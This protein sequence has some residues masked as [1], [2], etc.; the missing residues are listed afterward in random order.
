MKKWLCVG[1]FGLSIL[2]TSLL[3][4]ARAAEYITNGGFEETDWSLNGG[5]PTSHHYVYKNGT[6]SGEVDGWTYTPNTTTTDYGFGTDVATTTSLV[7]FVAEGD[8]A[9]FMQREGQVAQSINLTSGNYYTLTFKYNARNYQTTLNTKVGSMAVFNKQYNRTD[10]GYQTYTVTFRADSGSTA[11]TFA[12]TQSSATDNTV[13]LDA[14]SLQDASVDNPWTVPD[15]TSLWVSDATSNVNADKTY[16]HTLNFGNAAS[17]TTTLNNVSFAGV[18]SASSST[19]LYSVSAVS[20]Y[21][22]DSNLRS[23]FGDSNPGSQAMATFIY[24][25]SNITLKDLLPGQEYTTTFYLAKF[26][27][28]LRPGTITA[29]DGTTIAFDASNF[30]TDGTTPVGGLVT[31][32][33]VASAD[34]TLSF[35]IANTAADTLH[36][37]GISNEIVAGQTADKSRTSLLLATGFGG[38][39]GTGNNGKYMIDTTADICNF[40]TPEGE[41]NKW[42]MRGVFHEGGTGYYNV[43]ENGALRTKAN[44]GSTMAID[45]SVLAGEWIE[46]SMDFKMNTIETDNNSANARGIGLGFYSEDVGGLTQE[47]GIGFNGVIVD[48]SGRLYFYDNLDGTYSVS[49]LIAYEGGEFNKDDWYTLSLLLAFD[50]DGESATLV[51][52][53]LSGSSADYSSLAGSL[54]DTTDLLGLLSSS[55]YS[56]NYYGLIDNLEVKYY[57]PEPAS[58]ALLLL[59]LAGGVY[60]RR[61]VSRKR[62]LAR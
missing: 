17:S 59:A 53:S 6:I 27:D 61:G 9:L 50:E 46:M 19:D 36:I 4:P 54:F 7:P 35:N 43:I 51:D 37:Y 14:V 44:S 8:Y 38:T 48:P 40:L 29:P 24:N 58:W 56:W 23:S 34:G 32:T 28:S 33:G 42:G 57:T 55:A 20:T 45:K 5:T 21:G 25:A 3:A 11:L 1:I 18:T 47:V 49:D 13:L 39:N 15:S 30:T 22:T 2:S 52:V 41:S 60:M 62:T 10:G 16:T 26:G 31:W 12:N